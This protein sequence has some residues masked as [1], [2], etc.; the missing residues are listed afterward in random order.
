MPAHAIARPL[1]GEVAAY[2]EQHGGEPAR[3]RTLRPASRCVPFRI[4]SAATQRR[5]RAGRL[6]EAAGLYERAA[7]ALQDAGQRGAAFDAF[8]AAQDLLSESTFVQRLE[9][10]IDA[11]DALAD[12]D[13]G[14]RALAACARIVLLG[15][16]GRHDDADAA[17]A[18]GAALGGA[19]QPA[20]RAGRAALGSRRTALDAPPNSPRPRDTPSRRW[21]A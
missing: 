20:R 6:L 10:L 16:Q 2:L 21:R 13:D 11:L 4:W 12:N 9:G 5:A 1:H 7:H 3:G 19:R 14:R 18:A 15:E 17:G 8:F